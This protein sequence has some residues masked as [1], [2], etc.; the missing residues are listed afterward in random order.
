MTD[1]IFCK[2]ASGEIPSTKVYEDDL[3]LAFRDLE[4]QA[5]EHILIIPKVHRKSLLDLRAE[6][7]NL[8][9]HIY[10][11]VIPAIAKDLGL[12]E[13]GFRVVTN[14]GAEG[15]QTVGH[16]HFHLLGGRS[17]AWPPG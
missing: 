3:V 1:C 16:L 11:D 10:V 14:T 6:D 8:A 4:P 2:I 15:G 13:K 5:P 9:A 12:A 17:M 7:R